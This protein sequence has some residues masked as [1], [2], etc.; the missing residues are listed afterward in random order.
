MR[1]TGGHGRVESAGARRRGDVC[2]S[3]S[4]WGWWW[5]LSL[6]VLALLLNDRSEPPAGGG[7]DS[8]GQ[9]TSTAGARP[10]PVATS[11]QTAQAPTTAAPTGA[12][13]QL[14]QDPQ[15]TSVAGASDVTTDG[16][17]EPPGTARPATARVLGAAQSVDGGA[18]PPPASKASARASGA[19]AARPDGGAGGTAGHE[20][21]GVKVTAGG[22][23]GR[24]GSASG[25]EGRDEDGDFVLV[26]RFVQT[27]GA[28]LA[29]RVLDADSGRPVVGTT[30]EARLAGKYMKGTTD[31]SG[32]FRMPG[33]APS[34]KVVVWVGGRHDAFVEERID[35]PIPGE[36]QVA[37]TGT[38]RLLKGDEISPRLNGWV[39]LFVTRRSGRVIVSA[40]SPWLPAGSRRY[41]GGG[42]GGLDR[43]PGRRRLRPRRGHFPA[44]GPAGHD[45]VGRHRA[46]G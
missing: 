45:D 28:T 36:G 10:S 23:G 41:R 8:S 29:G 40:V 32:A 27:R 31:G 22:E 42:R 43:R 15:A 11:E 13:K 25:R 12:A 46:P 5:L 7:D 39:G 6:A 26:S 16:G 14:G 1:R 44:A 21:G 19:Q 33:M 38:I 35:V 37:D 24:R 18:G 20:D 30:I 4:G 34:S 2:H 17:A 3:R 9:A